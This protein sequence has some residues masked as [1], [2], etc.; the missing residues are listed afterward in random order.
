LTDDIV[1]LSRP[2]IFEQIKAVAK[3][4]RYSTIIEKG[5]GIRKEDEDYLREM[6]YKFAPNRHGA[7]HITWHLKGVADE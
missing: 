1:Y 7:W 6:G 3:T 5:K 4:G 2:Y